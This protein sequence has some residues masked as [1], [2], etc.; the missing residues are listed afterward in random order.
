M[1]QIVRCIDQNV[2][3]VSDTIRHMRER[4]LTYIA[5]TP[6]AEAARTAHVDETVAGTLIPETASWFM[7]ANIPGK[8]RGFLL[9]AGGL[10]V[11]RQKCA[12]VAALGY[13]GFV[14]E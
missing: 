6:A 11:F 9:Y 3:W 2:E 13:P 8:K 12:E 4:N 1:S 14:M 10:P 7:G 5:A